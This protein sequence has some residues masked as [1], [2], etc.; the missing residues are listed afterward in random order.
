MKVIYPACFYKDVKGTYS[1]VF[2]DLD[3]AT[4]GDSLDYAMGMAIDLLAG[5]IYTAKLE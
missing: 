2:N 5:H 1:V 4:C 3:I